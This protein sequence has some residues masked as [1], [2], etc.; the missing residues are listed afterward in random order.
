MW[1]PGQSGNPS[2]R[3]PKSLLARKLEQMCNDPEIVEQILEQTKRTLTTKGMAGVLMQERILDRVDGKPV[4]PI[5]GDL[6][7]ALKLSERMKQA[8]ERLNGGRE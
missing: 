6:T 7:I 4:Q 2:G 5:E 8:E 3:P 1:K